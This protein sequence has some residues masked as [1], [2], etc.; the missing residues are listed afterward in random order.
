[1]FCF[2]KFVFFFFS[3]PF[4]F[5]RFQCFVIGRSR[6]YLNLPYLFFY[7]RISYLHLFSTWTFYSSYFSFIFYL[8]YYFLYHSR[9][10]YIFYLDLSTS[11]LPLFSNISFLFPSSLSSFISHLRSF[12]FPSVSIF[13]LTTFFPFFFFIC[14]CFPLWLSHSPS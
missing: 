14:L 8:V 2:L 3:R 10:S 7:L 1:M 6:V 5:H 11:S 9:T 13:Y 4:I 12:H